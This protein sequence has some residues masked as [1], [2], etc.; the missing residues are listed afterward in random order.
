VDGLARVF[1]VYTPEQRA[2]GR[3]PDADGPLSYDLMAADTIA[4]IEHVI[5]QPVYL[6]GCSDGAVVALAVARR[7]PDLVRRLAF[8]T[9]VF[10]HDGWEKGVLDG[11]PPEWLRQ[12]YGELSPD[13]IGHYGV[14]VAKLA[15]M[16]ASEPVLTEA[17][18]RQVTVRTLIMVADDDEVRFEHA[19]AMYRSMPDAELTVVP[20]TSHGLL[21]EKADLC[22]YLMTEFL[23]KDPVQTFAPIRRAGS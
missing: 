10:H 12:S 17:D 18:L 4:F 8:A 3:T 23:T 16:H 22:N 6:M 11:E 5:G 21:V 20:G 1:R 15:A 7:R 13:G 19:V 9:G 2:H 14:V